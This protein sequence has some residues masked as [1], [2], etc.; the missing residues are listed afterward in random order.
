MWCFD[1]YYK[2]TVLKLFRKSIVDQVGED[3]SLFHEVL[4][5]ESYSSGTHH[6]LVVLVDLLPLLP[7]VT[8]EVR[9]RAFLSCDLRLVLRG[10][11]ACVCIQSYEGAGFILVSLK[12]SITKESQQTEVPLEP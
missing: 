10:K 7:F 1:K 2:K 12:P 6:F 3:H 11:E 8:R 9:V 5:G 4:V